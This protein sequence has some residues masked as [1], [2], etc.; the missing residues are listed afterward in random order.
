MKF[1]RCAKKVSGAKVIQF[2]GN[3]IIRGHC[4][5]STVSVDT[6]MNMYDYPYDERNIELNIGD[7]VI[8]THR[9]HFIYDDNVGLDRYIIIHPDGI[10][11][12]RDVDI[13]LIEEDNGS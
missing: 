8:I 7:L 3:G 13:D 5:R 4:E 10:T 11:W 6:E 9:Y 1:A 12:V 2:S